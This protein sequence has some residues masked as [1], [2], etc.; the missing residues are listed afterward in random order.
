M[1]FDQIEVVGHGGEDE[2]HF[3]DPAGDEVDGVAYHPEEEE[4]AN[5]GEQA[6]ADVEI[7]GVADE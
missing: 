5:T 4:D 7:H 1:I 2:D 6:V 3:L